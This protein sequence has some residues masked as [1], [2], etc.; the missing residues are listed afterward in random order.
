MY[1]SCVREG[2]EAE[3][4]CLEVHLHSLV[5]TIRKS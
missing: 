2:E 4:D 3:V 5:K 1:I